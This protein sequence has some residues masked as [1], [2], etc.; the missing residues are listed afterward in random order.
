MIRLSLMLHRGGREETLLA[1]IP[2]LCANIHVGLWGIWMDV[3]F[4]LL[5]NNPVQT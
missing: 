3:A 5:I 2:N 1:C 4:Y